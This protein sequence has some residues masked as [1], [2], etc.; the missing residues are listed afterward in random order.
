MNI[1]GTAEVPGAG[2]NALVIRY[3]DMVH[4]HSSL[5][6]VV[7]PYPCLSFAWNTKFCDFML[8]SFQVADLRST[9]STTQPIFALD[10]EM[11]LN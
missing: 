2:L 6:H 9:V 3:E 10:N 5:P 8:S 1:A 4:R 7:N 11:K